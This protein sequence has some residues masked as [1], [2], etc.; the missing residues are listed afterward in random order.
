MRNVDKYKKFR[1]YCFGED[2]LKRYGCSETNKDGHYIMDCS[3]ENGSPPK[4]YP[5]D[6]GVCPHCASKSKLIGTVSEGYTKTIGGT[7]ESD[8]RCTDEGY[9]REWYEK[10][11]E[12]TKEALKFKKGISPYAQFEM[13]FKVLEDQG[14][15]KKVSDKEARD[16]KER[17]NQVAASVADDFTDE[18]KQNKIGHRPNG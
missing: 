16:R 5:E 14:R 4:D 2:P 1:F 9:A 6:E 18:E 10:E 15:V 17:A 13:D 7:R 12:N 3:D 8:N 11:I